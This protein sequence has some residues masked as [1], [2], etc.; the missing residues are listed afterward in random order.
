MSS[1]A[2]LV[3]IGAIRNRLRACTEARVFQIHI[4]LIAVVCI[5]PCRRAA[6]A[7]CSRDELF[8][9]NTAARREKTAPIIF[10][11]RR[12]RNAAY[13]RQEKLCHQV[14][15]FSP[16]S[17]T[18]SPSNAAAESVALH[19]QSALHDPNMVRH[20]ERAA[21]RCTKLATDTNAWRSCTRRISDGILATTSRA[22]AQRKMIWCSNAG[23]DVVRTA[24]QDAFQCDDTK[25]GAILRKRKT[26]RCI[27]RWW[28]FRV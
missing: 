26:Q 5:H 1:C 4:V 19:H 22:E 23:G 15:P 14:F 12:Y 11:V 25:F 8:H 7:Q 17:A 18:M 6:V 3:I 20:F 2:V 27:S 21:Q 13:G 16:A 10:L 28:R 24:R 9:T